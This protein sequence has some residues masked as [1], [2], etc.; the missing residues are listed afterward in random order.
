MIC[1]K[2]EK[3]IGFRFQGVYIISSGIDTNVFMDA[4]FPKSFFYGTYKFRVSYT[5]NNEVYACFTFVVEVKR[6]WETE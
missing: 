1:Y 2:D 4:N 6:T 5:K 3:K